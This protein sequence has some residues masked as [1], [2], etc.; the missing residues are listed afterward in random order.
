MILENDVVDAVCVHLIAQGYQVAHC[1]AHERGHDIDATHPKKKRLLIEAKGEG[2][3]KPT[4]KRYGHAFNRNQVN[5]HVGRAILRALHYRA[6]SIASGIAL[7][8]N[9]DHRREV[10]P[11][12]P[13]LKK[14]GI[15]VFFVDAKLLVKEL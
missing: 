14:I 6:Q 11:I 9:P 13:L 8:D 1:H 15:S 12:F 2:S 4:S 5:D 3:S 7:P 10:D